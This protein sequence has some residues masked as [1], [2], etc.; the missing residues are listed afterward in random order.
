MFLGGIGL[1]WWMMIDVLFYVCRGFWCSFLLLTNEPLSSAGWLV[2]FAAV[3]FLLIGASWTSGRFTTS[4]W[5]WRVKCRCCCR[6]RTFVLIM[7]WKIWTPP[8][9]MGLLAHAA[10]FGF[11]FRKLRWV[12]IFWGGKKQL[13]EKTRLK[14]KR[15]APRL[16]VCMMWH[17]PVLDDRE[18]I[19][20]S[21]IQIMDVLLVV[22]TSL[23]LICPSGRFQHISACFD[24]GQYATG[25]QQIGIMHDELC[26]EHR[27]R[28]FLPQTV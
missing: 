20:K 7:R 1:T 25:L 28:N 14:S 6:V 18:Y 15:N 26:T 4:S 21:R 17:S 24:L 5:S 11:A 22:R 27:T 2:I 13:E 16:S 10:K 19:Q 3:F 23:K 12:R 8:Q 9:Q